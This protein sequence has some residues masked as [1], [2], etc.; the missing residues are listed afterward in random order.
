MDTQTVNT[1]RKILSQVVSSILVEC[2][3]D[4]CEKQVLET[5][6]E[7]LQ[8]FIVEIGASGRN[9]CEL[10]GRTEP[11]IADVILALINMG[12]K[13]DN[14]ET[15]A[16]RQSRTVLPTLQQQTQAKQLNILQ[17]GVKQGHPSHIPNYL[18]YFPDPHAYIRTPTHKQPVTEYEAI[19]EKVAT[20]KRDIERALTRFIAKTGETHSLFLTEDNSMFPLISCKPQ[21]PSYISALLPQDQIFEPDPEFQFDSSPVKKKKEQQT[22]DR[23]TEEGNQTQNEN[24]EQNGETI[25]QQDVIDN[26]Y[27]RP[28]KIPKNKMSSTTMGQHSVTK[29]LLE[30]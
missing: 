4:T 10:S 3:Y 7:M 9:Y 21:F 8:S 16:K 30:C 26:P 14:I 27:L 29:E 15:Y 11:L 20:Q 24:M 12:I 25:T 17:A 2:G 5:L 23:L 13:L 6:T 18:P 28:G 19:R 22:E 1:R